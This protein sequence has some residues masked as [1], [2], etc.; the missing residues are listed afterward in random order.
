MESFYDI[1]M[2]QRLLSKLFEPEG[3]TP[4]EL[5]LR[6]ITNQVAREYSQTAHCAA[7]LSSNHNTRWNSCNSAACS[8]CRRSCCPRSSLRRRS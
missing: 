3:V 2:F 8:C 6:E 5:Q 1:L 7:S 4:L